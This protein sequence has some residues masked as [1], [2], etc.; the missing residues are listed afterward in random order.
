M[1]KFEFGFVCLGGGGGIYRFLKARKRESL[2][3]GFKSVGL[4][5]NLYLDRPLLPGI[6]NVYVHVYWA[7]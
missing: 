5:S 4:E 1:S 2:G 3:E 6:V 7:M